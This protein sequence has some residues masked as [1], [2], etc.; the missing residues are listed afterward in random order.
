MEHKSLEKKRQVF[1]L[2]IV[3]CQLDAN[4]LSCDTVVAVVMPHAVRWHLI[5]STIIIY[6]E[7][8][9]FNTLSCLLALHTR[10]QHC[11]LTILLFLHSTCSLPFLPLRVF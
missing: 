1:K 7:Y 3:E 6:I 4:I 11:T 9:T 5:F 10:T 2:L 8:N